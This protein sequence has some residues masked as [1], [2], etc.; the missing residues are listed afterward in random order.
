M[1]SAPNIAVVILNYNSVQYTLR[2]V[3]SIRRHTADL[4]RVSLIVVDNNSSTADRQQL[5][6]LVSH[7]LRVIQSGR[8][9]GF[10][11]GMMLG[12]RSTAADY[13]FFLNN[14]CEFLNDVISI[15]CGFMQ[16]NAQAALCSASMRDADGRPRSSF[17][18]FPSL[19]LTLLG[20]GLLRF[21]RPRRFPDRR[22]LPDQPLPV[23]VVTGA[24][25]FV[26]GTAL[27]AL[28]G[29]DTHYFLYCEEE[30]F[31]LRV[32][33]AGWQTYCVPQAQIMHVGGASSGN[34]K[35]RP[36][37]QRE[38]YISFFRY[39]RLHHGASYALM[40]RAV[41][42]VKLLRRAM[43]GKAEFALVRF[44]LQGAPENA[45]LRYRQS[46]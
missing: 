17:N 16:D 12:A 6:Q 36:A 14:D 44:V 41:L 11:G 15:L 7:N 5:A 31:A 28:N 13:Y 27:H 19:T 23:D 46:A 9:L 24:A 33:Q 34:F 38:F 3:D 29:L 1:P 4:S 35:L 25:M 40:F 32:K 45:S 20:S 22:K 21:L 42:A 39:L 37:M 10:S 43:A 26:R 2:C 18:Y 30:D 8:N